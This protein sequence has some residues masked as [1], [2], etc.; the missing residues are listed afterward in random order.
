MTCCRYGLFHRLSMRLSFDSPPLCP[1]L[2]RPPIAAGCFCCIPH[3]TK[4]H[5]SL[6]PSRCWLSA[7]RPSPVSSPTT[8]TG[9]RHTL[10]PGH[11]SS[12]R[13]KANSTPHSRTLTTS[14]S[15]DPSS[16]PCSSCHR[17]HP[18]PTSPTVTCC[19]PL[20]VHPALSAHSLHAYLC[21]IQSTPHQPIR[22]PLFRALSTPHNTHCILDAS[23][24]TCRFGGRAL[25]PPIPVRHTAF[26]LLE[27]LQH[28]LGPPPFFLAMC[29]Q[30]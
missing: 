25:V 29:T 11:S 7:S 26:A 30:R 10:P 17:S 9:P 22:L 13:N 24:R 3:F 21:C 1:H 27:R 14:P 12:P 28:P 6:P 15:S 23:L 16:P 8:S 2:T 4:E 18:E 20:R 19:F 5:S